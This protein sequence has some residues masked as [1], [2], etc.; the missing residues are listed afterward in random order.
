MLDGAPN[1]DPVPI[2]RRHEAMGLDCEMGDDREGVG[3][4]HHQVCGRRVDV[5]PPEAVLTQDVGAGQRVVGAQ[6]GLLNQRRPRI[7]CLGDAEDSGQHLVLHDNE[8][9]GGLGGVLGLCGDRRH[10][11]AVVLGLADGKDGPVLKLRAEAWHRLREVGSSHDEAHSWHL[12][13]C[14]GVDAENS[15][16]GDVERNQLDMERVGLADVGEVLLLAGDSLMPADAACRDPGTVGAH[17]L[18][19][20]A[21]ARTA[22]VICWYPAHRHRL[23]TRPSWTSSTVGSGFRA[24]SAWAD[25]NWPGIQKPH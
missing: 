1:H 6:P 20:S 9:G 17:R 19:D 12:L 8:A 23:P 10:R 16:P 18:T 25:I 3:V 2:R 24:S 4:L 22:S 5:T 13:G 11:L 14:R 21:A 7:E 15:G